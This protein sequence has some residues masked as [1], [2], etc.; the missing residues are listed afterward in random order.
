MHGFLKVSS[1]SNSQQLHT[2]LLGADPEL[3]FGGALLSLLCE[4]FLNNIV[5]YRKHLTFGSMPPGST[6]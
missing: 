3:D 5:C 4:T 1:M 2:T 6:P